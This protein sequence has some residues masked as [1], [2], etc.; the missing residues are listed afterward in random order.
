M[1][2]HATYYLELSTRYALMQCYRDV[3]CWCVDPFNG[4]MVEGSMGPPDTVVCVCEL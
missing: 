1:M 4:T 3:E 2:L